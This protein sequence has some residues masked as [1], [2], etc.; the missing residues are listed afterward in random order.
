MKSNKKSLT[1]RTINSFFLLTSGSISISILKLLTLAILARIIFQEDFGAVGIALIIIE[2]A[3]VLSTLGLDQALIQKESIDEEEISASF[4]IV[5]ISSIMI[6]IIIILLTPYVNLIFAIKNL[7]KI[8]IAMSIVIPL[9]SMS[10]ISES[11]FSKEM[12]F[13]FLIKTKTISYAAGY[14]LITIVL[15]LNGYG[16]WA[17]VIGH[18]SQ[19]IILSS[20]LLR[21]CPHKKLR[22]PTIKIF[23]QINRIRNFSTNILFTKIIL[24]F[25]DN[26]DK[27]IIASKLGAYSLGIYERSFK[28]ANTPQNYIGNNLSISLFPA[29]SKKQDS[30]ESLYRAY[31]KSLLFITLTCVPISIIG[32]FFANQIILILLGKNWASAIPIFRIFSLGIFFGVADKLQI[33]TLKSINKTKSLVLIKLVYALIVFV[34]SL[35]FIKEGI[36]TIAMIV[37]FAGIINFIVSTIVIFSTNFNKHT[38]EF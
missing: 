6:S 4:T 17:L 14:G 24:F 37:L 26:I 5:L 31:K 19:S 28:I 32:F 30:S 13:K 11:L 9:R 29:M 12:N 3:I 22:N 34:G 21:K 16:I 18:I 27:S 8:I 15:A 33:T 38:E 36:T 2:F 35:Y 20:L 1:S 10:L 25:A 23:N 7:N